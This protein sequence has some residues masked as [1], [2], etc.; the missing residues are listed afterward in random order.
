MWRDFAIKSPRIA[1]AGLN[2]HAGEAG[3]FGREEIEVIRPVIEQFEAEIQEMGRHKD[4]LL[5]PD[6]RSMASGY[7]FPPRRYG[8]I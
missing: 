1:V 8:R 6:Q 3:K 4:R 2:P 7:R 5:P